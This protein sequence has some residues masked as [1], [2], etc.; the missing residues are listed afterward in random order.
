MKL[1]CYG[2][3]NNLGLCGFTEDECAF[4]F[5]AS[6]AS[7][8]LTAV[9]SWFSACR[10]LSLCFIEMLSFCIRKANG[11]LYVSVWVCV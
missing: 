3:D 4:K 7:V 5:G 11:A 6:E 9:S 1:L 10:S 8:P 2:C